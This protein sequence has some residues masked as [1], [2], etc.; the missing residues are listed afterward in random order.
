M[1]AACTRKTWMT[2]VQVVQEATIIKPVRF[3]LHELTHPPRSRLSVVRCKELAPTSS[4][5]L[6]QC[7][8]VLAPGNRYR[9]MMRA[10]PMSQQ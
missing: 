10:T 5:T 6:F 1:A 4:F 3:L 9:A 7:E 2:T 8:R